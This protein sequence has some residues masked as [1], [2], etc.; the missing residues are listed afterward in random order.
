[1]I[2]IHC[3]CC[4]AVLSQQWEFFL[5]IV[6]FFSTKWV[7][8]DALSFSFRVLQFFREGCK[9]RRYDKPSLPLSL[10]CNCYSEE[11]VSV[12]CKKKVNKR[13]SSVHG[14]QE[15]FQRLVVHVSH[16]R[17]LRWYGIRLI[18]LYNQNVLSSWYEPLNK[19]RPRISAAPET[20]IIKWAPRRLFE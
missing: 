12:C 17:R 16:T 5:S 18:K 1:M 4:N 6:M 19:R 8:L 20:R 14:Q 9:L 15:Y 11:M 7:Y 10:L 2:R 13:D 3:N